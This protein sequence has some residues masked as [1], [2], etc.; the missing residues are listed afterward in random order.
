MNLAAHS[1]TKRYGTASEYE[2]VRDASLELRAGEFVAVSRRDG[3]EKE[4]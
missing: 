3:K 2:A 4:R 1:L